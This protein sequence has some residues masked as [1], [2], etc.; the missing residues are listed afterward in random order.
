M[1]VRIP[2]KRK[3]RVKIAVE[4]WEAWQVAR[5]AGTEIRLLVYFR[6]KASAYQ[7]GVSD[8]TSELHPLLPS[9]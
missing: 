4:S 8:D 7:H 5:S 2:P 9:F 1:R 6:P 3:L